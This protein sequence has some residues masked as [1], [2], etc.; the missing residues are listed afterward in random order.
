MMFAKQQQISGY[1]LLLK[2]PVHHV[3]AAVHH[4][5]MLPAFLEP[6]KVR[7]AAWE[8]P[9]LSCPCLS[10]LTLRG[11]GVHHSADLQVTAYTSSDTVTISVE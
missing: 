7:G 10:L 1:D 2:T 4:Q 6:E 11:A 3:V 9:A 8:I 5:N